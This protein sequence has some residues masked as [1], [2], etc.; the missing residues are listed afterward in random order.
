MEFKCKYRN[1]NNN[2]L[3]S[4]IRPK[5]NEENKTQTNRTGIV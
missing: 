5:V 2:I 4:L 3:E 1:K